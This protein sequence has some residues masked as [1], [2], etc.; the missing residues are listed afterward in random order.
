MWRRK[1]GRKRFIV[2][3][4]VQ[5]ALFSFLLMGTAQANAAQDGKDGF[6]IEADRVEG[7]GITTGI[8]RQETSS[9][10][11]KPMLRIQYSKATIYGM[12]V[13][14]R[15]QSSDGPVS[16]TLAAKGPVTVT[17]MTVDTTA[18]SFQ[19]ACLKANTVLPEAGLEK[20]VMVAHYM[21][22]DNS[23]IDQLS[24]NTMAGNVGSPVPERLI[25]SKI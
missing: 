24:L 12:K 16:I 22:A 1:R 21:K 3:I 6:V 7:S 9:A 14:K 11:G 2:S 10:S 15:I 4:S 23:I 13:T 19:G 20:V 25:L 8:I 5:L 18:L 17:G